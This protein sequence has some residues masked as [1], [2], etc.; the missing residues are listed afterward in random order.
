MHV[1]NLIGRRLQ[2]PTKRLLVLSLVALVIISKI[3]LNKKELN[4][5]CMSLPLGSS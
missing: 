3:N 4:I 5:S 2:Y 1:L